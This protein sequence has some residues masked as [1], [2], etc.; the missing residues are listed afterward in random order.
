MWV[1]ARSI[2]C[3]CVQ[4]AAVTGIKEVE[5]GCDKEGMVS[6]GTTREENV[7]EEV[8]KQDEYILSQNICK[9]FWCKLIPIFILDVLFLTIFIRLLYMVANIFRFKYFPK[10]YMLH[11]TPWLV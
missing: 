4:A 10:T 6:E 3:R 1:L 11:K 8:A 9:F 2:A 7:T 5:S